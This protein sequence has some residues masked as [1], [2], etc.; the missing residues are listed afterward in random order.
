MLIGS[1][2][3]VVVGICVPVGEAPGM[4]VPVEISVM[5]GMV[6]V[7]NGGAAGAFVVQ[8]ASMISE[9]TTKVSRFIW[10]FSLTP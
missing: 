1:G 8:P 5:A 3:G 10:D 7:G 9:S 4:G 2:M 6:G